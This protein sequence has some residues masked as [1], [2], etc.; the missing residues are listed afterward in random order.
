MISSIKYILRRIQLILYR[1]KNFFLKPQYP[2]NKDG[3]ILIHLGCGDINC[4]AFI[5]VDS[6]FF[7]HIHHIHNIEYLP[8]FNDEFADLMYASHTLE[9]VSMLKVS[10]VLTEWKRIL[11][12]AE[13]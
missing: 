4:P 7:P 11:K 10:Q 12:K 9:H 13:Y 5:N 3:K 6:R 1:I 8:M 2:Q